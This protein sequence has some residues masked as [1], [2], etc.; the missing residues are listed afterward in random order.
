LTAAAM[1]LAIIVVTAA[2]IGD[3]NLIEVPF[4]LLDRIEQ[5]E[6]DDIVPAV[7]LHAHGAG[8]RQ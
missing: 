3:I 6:I 4:G 7:I 8:H 5:H 1:A 2:L